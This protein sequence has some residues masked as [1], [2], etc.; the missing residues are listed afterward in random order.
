MTHQ[1]SDNE[2]NHTVTTPYN[3]TLFQTPFF[4]L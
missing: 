4:P 2:F 3:T 1:A